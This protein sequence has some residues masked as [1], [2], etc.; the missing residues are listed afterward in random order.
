LHD[1]WSR[2]EGPYRKTKEDELCLSVS[3]RPIP[4]G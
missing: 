1:A 3:H 4:P 2:R